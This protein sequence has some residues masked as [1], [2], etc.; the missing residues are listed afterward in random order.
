MLSVIPSPTFLS[1]FNTIVSSIVMSHEQIV[2]N[3][4]FKKNV[5]SIVM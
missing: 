4:N 1:V 3:Q 5:S 2:K